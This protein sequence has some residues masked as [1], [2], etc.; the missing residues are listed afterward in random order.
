MKNKVI[1]AYLVNIPEGRK[2]GFPKVFVGNILPTCFTEWCID[3]G[4]PKKLVKYYGK[5][6]IITLTKLNMR[7]T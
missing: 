7:K 2:Y 5:S 1:E 3:E 4:Y 6:F